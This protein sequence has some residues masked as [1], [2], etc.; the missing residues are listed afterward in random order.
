MN[1]NDLVVEILVNGNPITEYKHEGQIYVEGRENSEYAIRI[2][3]NS[4]KNRLVIPSVD[5]L[6]TLDGKEASTKSP[7]YIINKNSELIIPGRMIDNNTVANFV[8]SNTQESY[9]V[10]RG[11]SPKNNGI[12][13]LLVYDEKSYTLYRNKSDYNFLIASNLIQTKPPNF[14]RTSSVTLSA[15][16][17][18][19]D[20]SSSLGTGWGTEK[21]FKTV[22]KNFNRDEST[23]FLIEIFY[24]DEKGLKRRGIQIGKVNTRPVAFVD[25]ET[26]GC[27]RP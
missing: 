6:S 4:N 22:E 2:K 12:I 13:G 10:R 5:G 3:N 18:I 27:P 1:K 21:E 11:I 23:R 26:I 25:I 8:F 16:K 14:L 15:T 7:G 24:D 20:N 17:G 19:E 9:N